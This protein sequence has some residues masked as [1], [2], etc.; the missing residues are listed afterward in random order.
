VLTWREERI[1]EAFEMGKVNGEKEKRA[2]EQIERDNIRLV[3][4]TER[5]NSLC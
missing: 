3:E 1:D 5:E 2:A 4:Q